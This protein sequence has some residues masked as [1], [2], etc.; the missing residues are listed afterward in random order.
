MEHRSEVGIMKKILIFITLVLITLSSLFA[1]YLP[2]LEETDRI[3][4][5]YR[6]GASFGLINEGIYSFP[7]RSNADGTTSLYPGLSL[8]SDF[9]KNDTKTNIGLSLSFDISYPILSSKYTNGIKESV[10]KNN[11]SLFLSFGPVV[12]FV[13]SFY[14]DVSFALRAYLATLDY[15]KSGV[16]FGLSIEPRVDY[17]L[18]DY[19]FVSFSINTSASAFKIGSDSDVIDESYSSLATKAI[20]ALGYKIGDKRR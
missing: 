11:L 7:V 6:F 20:F 5:Y 8:S 18:Y 10:K 9:Y 19:L 15:F 16:S 4:T 1:I 13:P 14:F 3:S 2:E 17:F 12:R